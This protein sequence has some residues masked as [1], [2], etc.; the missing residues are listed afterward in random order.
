VTRC[1]LVNASRRGRAVDIELTSLSQIITLPEERLRPRS[2]TVSGGT[3]SL[4]GLPS[5][6]KADVGVLHCGHRMRRAV[7]G[8]ALTA[9]IGRLLVGRVWLVDQVSRYR[10]RLSV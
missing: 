7:D 9:P 3:S 4:S 1:S 2:T 10:T 6:V 5:Y 8:D